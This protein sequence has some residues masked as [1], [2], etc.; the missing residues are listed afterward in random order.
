M[1]SDDRM[2]E[3]DYDKAEERVEEDLDEK[4][5]NYSSNPYNLIE[6]EPQGFRDRIRYDTETKFDSLSDL[7]KHA[8][9]YG[10]AGHD[11]PIE[12]IESAVGEVIKGLEKKEEDTEVESE[13]EEAMSNIQ[14]DF[15]LQTMYNTLKNNWNNYRFEQNNDMNDLTNINRDK[16]KGGIT[17][18]DYSAKKLAELIEKQGSITES[19]SIFLSD[20]VYSATFDGEDQTKDEAVQ[21]ARSDILGIDNNDPYFM[22]S[23]MNIDDDIRTSLKNLQRLF[24]IFEE[25]KKQDK[26][27]GN[28]E[29]ESHILYSISY[30]SRNIKDRYDNNIFNLTQWMTD[31]KMFDTETY[32]YLSKLLVES[33]FRKKN[34]GQP[35]KIVD[36]DDNNIIND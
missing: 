25:E 14:N 21:T 9:M 15:N 30:M 19:V 13:V 1:E 22:D 8:I 10:Y 20:I 33:N 5:V 26:F 34:K 23:D 31:R 29:N 12:E 27:N 28:P 6:D 32:K 24:E 7:I 11:V 17:V 35:V 18:I 16:S 36:F 4:M 2:G 3:L